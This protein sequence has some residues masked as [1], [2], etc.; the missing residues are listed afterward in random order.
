[1][2]I[3]ASA[4]LV[5][6]SGLYKIGA[7]GAYRF[8]TACPR[9]ESAGTN[10]PRTSLAP[11]RKDTTTGGPATPTTGAPPGDATTEHLGGRCVGNSY[12]LIRPIGHGATGTVWRAVDR[13]NGDQ[14]AVKLLRED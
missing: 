3:W 7:F 1:M 9:T 11:P 6:L 2:S 4:A 5:P 10:G 12:I 13:T 14:V 8:R